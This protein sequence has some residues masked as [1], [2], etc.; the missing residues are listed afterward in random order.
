M[1]IYLT[2][3][4]GFLGQEIVRKT[5][6]EANKVYVPIRDKYGKTNTER[7]NEIFPKNDDSKLILKNTNDAIPDDTNIIILNAFEVK[8]TGSIREKVIQNIEP[9]IKLL[10]AAKS[11]PNLKKVIIVST[12]YVNPPSPVKYNE[13]LVP[14]GTFDPI[15]LYD[16]I[17]NEKITI[18]KISLDPKIDS[19]FTENSYVFSKRLME[20]VISIKYDNDLPITFIRPSM[21]SVSSCGTYGNGTFGALLCAKLALYPFPLTTFDMVM[22]DHI[23]VDDVAYGIVKSI[24]TKSKFVYLSCGPKINAPKFIYS[25][26]KRRKILF[27]K[28]TKYMFVIKM[29]RSFEY[30]IIMSIYGRKKANHMK[31]IYNNYD[32][33]FQNEWIFPE[34]VS[35]NI[36]KYYKNVKKWLL[37]THNS[38][39]IKHKNYIQ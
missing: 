37:N 33:V 39:R 30:L 25:L 8:F 17:L 36:D 3:S 34:T 16:D 4:S 6:D 9:M 7:F 24:E 14:L 19:H 28:S 29:I 13:G 26:N 18:E 1:N 22:Y 31:S 23:H 38:N 20:H 5:I 10:D 15:K 12:A 11:L 21:I 2:G 32:Y 27:F 35:L